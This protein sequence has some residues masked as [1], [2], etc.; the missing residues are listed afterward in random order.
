MVQVL[1]TEFL[2]EWPTFESVI[3]HKYQCTVSRLVSSYHVVQ[4]LSK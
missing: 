1:A 3:V 4:K 2:Q